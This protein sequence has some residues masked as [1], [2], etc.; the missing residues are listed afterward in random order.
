MRR[1]D[2]SNKQEFEFKVRNVIE[3]DS[4]LRQEADSIDTRRDTTTR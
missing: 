2:D 4:T 1:D 3:E